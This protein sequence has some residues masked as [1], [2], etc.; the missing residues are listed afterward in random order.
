MKT[1]AIIAEFNPLHNGHVYLMEQAREAGADHVLVVMSGNFVQRGEPAVFNRYVRAEAAVRCGADAVLTLPSRF[2]TASAEKYADANIRALCGLHCVD[3]LIFG[4]ECGDLKQL[5]DCAKILAEEPEDYR[6]KLKA[7]LKKGLS[8]P[9]ARAEALPGY[10]RLLREPNNILAVEYLKSMQRRNASFQAL[11]VQRKGAAY[12][13]KSYSGEYGQ[14]GSGIY[15]SAAAVRELMRTGRTDSPEY[16]EAVP[17]RA[18]V[19]FRHAADRMIVPEDF[20][21]ILA[22]ELFS[23][24]E[25][26]YFMAFEDVTDELARRIISER[27]HFAG[28]VS[29][30]KQ[31]ASKSLTISHTMRA[32]M[33]IALGIRKD[34]PYRDAAV[35]Q[36]LAS[37][38]EAEPLLKAI[39]S[40]TDIPVAIRQKADLQ[41]MP[42]KEAM[43]FSEEMRI[44]NIYGLLE[45]M[46]SGEPFINEYE[47][48]IVKV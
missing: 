6:E 48:R 25:A 34:V 46:K 28:F 16:S 7:G 41:N 9:K 1:A 39:R 5:G 47:R 23:A 21:A 18:A 33:H 20:S 30:S 36:L 32:L 29:F 10:E 42:S 15:A 19:L 3:F 12:H 43:L 24:D 31:I 8:F 22:A 4:S 2:S 35:L 14:D 38:K 11:T 44:S 27:N 13:D 37:G 40:G 45:A 17:P 26:D